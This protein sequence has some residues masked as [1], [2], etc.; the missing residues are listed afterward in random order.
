[1]ASFGA[2]W[3]SCF[4][5]AGPG[6][7]FALSCILY[8]LAN[9]AFGNSFL[10]DLSGFLDVCF[11]GDFSL[12]ASFLTSVLALAGDTGT[13]FFY[14]STFYGLGYDNFLGLS[15]G[16]DLTGDCYLSIASCC[17]LASFSLFSR[18]FWVSLISLFFKG[19]STTTGSEDFFGV[20][21]FF[22]C[23]FFLSLDLDLSTFL[24]LYFYWVD[25]CLGVSTS[26]AFG[27]DFSDYLTLSYC[28]NG[29]YLTWTKAYYSYFAGVFYTSFLGVCTC[30]AASF[31]GVLVFSALLAGVFALY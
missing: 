11:L 28:F 30:L 24:G 20:C 29:S 26:F 10:G 25:F 21:C 15:L 5:G 19:S 8:L 22:N 2:T 1:L 18:T 9:G 31:A 27:L 16:L 7:D 6:A 17:L 23:S 4:Y 3:C 13:C 12:G 14:S